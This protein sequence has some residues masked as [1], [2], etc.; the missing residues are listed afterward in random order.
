MTISEA[1]EK[2]KTIKDNA[3]VDEYVKSILSCAIENLSYYKNILGDIELNESIKKEIESKDSRLAYCTVDHK[4]A[5]DLFKSVL[6]IWEDKKCKSQLEDKKEK[7]ITR[8]V[9]KI[10]KELS[11]RNSSSL[12]DDI[13]P[14]WFREFN[15]VCKKADGSTIEKNGSNE[16]TEERSINKLQIGLLITYVIIAIIGIVVSKVVFGKQQNGGN[17]TDVF[18]FGLESLKD[19][20]D[21]I[22]GVL[23]VTSGVALGGEIIASKKPEYYK[24][25]NIIIY[26]I[27]LALAFAAVATLIYLICM[28]RFSYKV[29]LRVFYIIGG[30]LA[31]IDFIMAIAIIIKIIIK[32][33]E[34]ELQQ[35][36][37]KDKLKEN[38]NK[39]IWV[40]IGNITS[41]VICFLGVVLYATFASI[42]WLPMEHHYKVEPT[43]TSVGSNCEYWK[44]KYLPMYFLDADGKQR[45]AEEDVVIPMLPHEF[46][47]IPRRE[48]TETTIGWEEYEKCKN[49]GYTTNYTEIPVLPATENVSVQQLKYQQLDDGTYEVVGM[50]NTQ[51]KSSLSIPESYNGVRVTS[52]GEYAFMDCVELTSVIIPESVTSIGEGAF[53]GCSN[54]AEITLPFVG[55][56]KTANGGFDQVFGYIFGYTIINSDEDLPIPGATGIYMTSNLDKIYGY[57]IPI[58]LKSVTITGGNI[59]EYAFYGCTQLTEIKMSDN[60][61]SI[62]GGAFWSCSGL[63]SINIPN[64]V[65][66]IGQHMFSGCS[67]LKNI[68]IPDSVTSIEYAAF[69]NCTGL[70]SIVIPKSVVKIGERVFSGCNNLV[71]MAV[72][73]V[74]VLGYNAVFGY[75][76]DY[77]IVEEPGY[78]YQY[79]DGYDTDYYYDIPSSLKS[80]TITGGDVPH[81]AF[82]NCTGLTSITIS[83][84]VT[85]IGANAFYNCTGL[86]SITISDNVTSIGY[87]AFYNCIG[88][89]SIKIP[90]KTRDFSDNTFEG[91]VNIMSATMPT[92]AVSYIPKT[93][94]RTVVITSGT[95]I[96]S[97]AFKNCTELTSITL[98]ESITS[99]GSS[100]FEGCCELK[101]IKIPSNVT[102]IGEWAFYDCSK[103]EEITIN[104]SIRVIGDNAFTY[105]SRLKYVYIDSA[106]V[107]AWK[108]SGSNLLRYAD[109][110]YIKDGLSVGSYITSQFSK[111]SYQDEP[112]Y[113]RYIKKYY[114]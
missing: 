55:S 39:K 90:D 83:D 96:G 56:S 9:N 77:S 58:S 43:C 25:K 35:V 42:F 17:E 14:E 101:S 78:T 82:Y 6:S 51:A 2:L 41:A 70:T 45:C 76:F 62:G 7:R 46:E 15:D 8:K 49:C 1:I 30:C 81:Y 20:L 105:C 67:S 27:L 13:I 21:L 92:E 97:D 102:S 108:S 59:P 16:P 111:S 66:K 73:F 11:D 54:L 86:T 109:Y 107:A 93:N 60:V 99:I 3:N 100:A 34:K 36:A 22:S 31:V 95:S 24:I 79:T 26:L 112:G 33:Q 72:P 53:K 18:L 85:S 61:T 50:E 104:D 106:V 113:V 23:G 98:P 47:I 68:T 69:E 4:W 74:G 19:I 94:L 71:E 64:K 91:C 5:D 37:E 48:P 114:T 44:N 75:L 84:N 63:N 12:E 103:L 57:Y 40:N 38:K 10:T 80:V 89:T 28:V 88:L 29:S 65:Q 32:H 52:I 110:V 87:N